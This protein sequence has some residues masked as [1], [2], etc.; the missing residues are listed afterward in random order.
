MELLFKSPPATVP[1]AAPTPFTEL[2]ELLP[3]LDADIKY[4][5]IKPDLITAT[6]EL[7]KLI[8]KPVYDAIVVIY[9]KDGR[10]KEEDELIYCTR[11]PI[12]VKAY[13]LL[14]PNNDIAHTSN[15]RKMRQDDKEKQAFEWMLDRDNDA[16]AARYHRA[17]DDMLEYLD[18]NLPAWKESDAYKDSHKLFVRT[19]QDF[20]KHFRI[21]SRYTLLQ[22]MPGLEQ[23]EQY[24]ILPRIGKERYNDLKD[25][26][27]E[28]SVLTEVQDLELMYLIRQACVYYSLAWG[29]TRLNVK[30]FPEGVLQA[31]TSDRITTKGKAPAVKAEV[32][33]ARESFTRDAQLAYSKIESLLAPPPASD[34]D[35]DDTGGFTFIRGSKF[36]ST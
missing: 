9:N 17:V 16:L 21:D 33:I 8:G 28:G 3:F 24:E 27:K 14:A 19:T 30:I 32:E 7:I 25:K 5:K 6:N 15:G 23:C 26:L 29:M 18:D 13:M 1:P 36:I 2:K 4:S 11:Y 35:T 34:Q 10:T 22:L 31:Y 12:A 20:D